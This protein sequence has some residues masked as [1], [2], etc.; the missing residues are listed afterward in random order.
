M[1]SAAVIY[2]HASAAVIYAHAEA[3]LR[4]HFYEFESFVRTQKIGGG[5]LPRIVL[6]PARAFS[7]S[8]NVAKVRLR[9]INNR[10]NS[11]LVATL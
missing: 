5:T 3:F 4:Q 8:E 10:T 2:R 7:I 6:S 11:S 9:I 1:L